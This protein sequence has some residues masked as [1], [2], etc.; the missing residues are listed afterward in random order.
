VVGLVSVLDKARHLGF[1]G[2]G[3]IEAH[4]D[5]AG[6]FAQAHEGPAPRRALDLGSGGGLPGL[7][8]ALTW[9]ESTWWL[10]DANER[11]S[12]FLLE[13]LEVL[14]L[15]GRARVL[16]GRAEVLGRDGEF[17]HSM[18][19]VTARSFGPPAVVA[20][21]AAPFLVVGGQ[22]LV[23]EPPDPSDRWDADG[24]RQVGLKSINQAFGCRILRQETLCPDRFPR[25]VGIPGKRPLFTTPPSKPRPTD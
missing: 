17:R 14:G 22:L 12:A 15:T 5:H 11:R 3:P 25:R 4:I 9:P 18:D 8:L 20:E 13:S 19:L 6:G 2:P 10:L 21:C 1:L 24:L 23:S 16:H 7:V